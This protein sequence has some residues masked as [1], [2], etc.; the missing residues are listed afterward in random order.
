[1]LPVQRSAGRFGTPDRD[2]FKRDKCV[3]TRHQTTLGGERLLSLVWFWLFGFWVVC[4]MVG[5]V[6]GTCSGWLDGCRVVG[7]CIRQGA[8]MA[9]PGGDVL[10]YVYVCV[11][12]YMYIYMYIYMI[13]YG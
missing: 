11:C 5:R 9:N 12:I 2:R 8:L 1:M 13:E 6:A 4:W 7:I 10:V 3:T